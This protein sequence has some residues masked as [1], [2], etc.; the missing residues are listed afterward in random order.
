MVLT[1]LRD[2]YF[3]TSKVPMSE[4]YSYIASEIE[5]DYIAWI[6]VTNRC[7]MNIF[8]NLLLKNLIKYLKN[9]TVS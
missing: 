1:H 7:A 6:N 2:K 3:S 9:M 8:I 5:G 4:V